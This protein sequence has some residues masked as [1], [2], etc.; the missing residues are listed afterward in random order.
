MRRYRRLGAVL[1]VAA[2]ATSACGRDPDK[3][4]SD[5][6][7]GDTTGVT[8]TSIKV[9]GTFPLTGVAAPGYSEIPKGIKAYFDYVNAQGGVHGRKIQWTVKDDGYNPTQTSAVT[10]ELVLKDKVFA[11]L[12]S[13]GTPTHEAVV[14]FLNDNKVPDIFVSSGSVAWGDDPD[15][16]PWT[17]GWQ[18]DYESEGK[19]IGQYIADN[20][21]DAKIG[22]FLQ[23][24]DFG[25]SGEA[26]LR[27]Y[28]D[29]QIVEV[30]K[31][32][33]GGTD[34]TPQVAALKASGADLVVGFNVP[35]YTALTQL[36]SLKVGYK[37]QWFY[38]NVGSDPTLVGALLANF[39]KGAVSNGASLL[40]GVMSTAY[41]PGV[42]QPDNPWV[43]LYQKVWDANGEGGPL[44]NYLV[45]G[46]SEAYT[47][48]QALQAAGQDLTR[49][50]LVDA[51][52]SDGG[53][54]KGPTYGPFR[55]SD[56]SHLGTSG[57]QV[58]KLAG[59][60]TQ[61][62]TDVLTTDIGDADIEK[63]DGEPATPPSNGIPK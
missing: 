52:A 27:K 36:V 41:L 14:D 43:T 24:D 16:Y 7:A 25:A 20:M 38:S 4:D 1:L 63:Y 39:S 54:F 51:L 30:Q 10:N 56:D 53:D 57:F 6:K 32:T 58:V 12:G 45:Y 17:F 11:M 46:M 62:L 22:L 18:T 59:G 21:P 19:V 23:D 47:F 37:P 48:V 28:V 3:R 50:G 8:D 60:A 13:L 34:V 49:E 55:Y 5:K 9:G 2:L 35:S 31:Y 42:D 15:K 61:P 40:D 26:G 33:P 44:T 29:K